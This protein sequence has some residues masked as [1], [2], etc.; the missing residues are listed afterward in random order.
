MIDQCCG[1]SAE[2]LN[3][4][5]D[6]GESN[7]GRLRRGRRRKRRKVAHAS[8]RVG[9]V[10]QPIYVYDPVESC[11]AIPVPPSPICAGLKGI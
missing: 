4:I 9:R 1:F 7:D 6:Y 8:P 5:M 11:C 3:L 10:A 2:V